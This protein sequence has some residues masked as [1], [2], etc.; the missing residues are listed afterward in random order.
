VTI[1]SDLI[2]AV[3]AAVKGHFESP[4]LHD[5][6]R[7]TPT[8]EGSFAAATTEIKRFFASLAL[9]DG[10]K[11]SA[12]RTPDAHGGEWL[13]DLT[14]YE[15]SGGF[16]R[17]QIL[18]LESEMHPG[19]T[20]ADCDHVDVDF[21]KLVQARAEIRVWVAALPS[22]ALL[23][24]HVE[25]CKRQIV[26]FSQ[27]EADDFYLFVLFDWTTGTTSVKGYRSPPSAHAAAGSNS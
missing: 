2:C 20:I 4:L 9:P 24:S 8:Q 19:Y 23:S 12:S 27:G 17:R 25:N 16:Y 3:E 5:L 22:A 26:N 18:V 21:H 7:G 1:Q 13:Y 15:E 6:L 10:F 11:V 14:W